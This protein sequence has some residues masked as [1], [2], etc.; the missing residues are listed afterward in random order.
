[1]FADL[2]AAGRAE[3]PVGVVDGGFQKFA[4]VA[5]DAC[6]VQRFSFRHELNL[7]QSIRLPA[8]W[9]MPV[10]SQDFSEITFLADHLLIYLANI[11]QFFRC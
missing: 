3:E 11:A 2:P 9:A 5:V 7:E 1:V 10:Y 6:R 4:N 8:S